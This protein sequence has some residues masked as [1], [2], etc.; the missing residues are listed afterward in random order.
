MYRSKFG[1]RLGAAII[2]ALVLLVIYTVL[3]PVLAVSADMAL[4]GSGPGVWVLVLLGSI[5]LVYSSF[6]IWTGQTPGKKALGIR[7]MSQEGVPASKGQLLARWAVK[8]SGFSLRIAAGITGLAALADIEG[9]CGLI[10][11]LGCFLA[12]GSS[13]MALHDRITGT[14]VFPT[15]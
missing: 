1:A 12:L 14:A 4:R 9:L 15:S 13:C 2:D 10:V 5:P 6:E 8:Y 11:F 3:L 7:I